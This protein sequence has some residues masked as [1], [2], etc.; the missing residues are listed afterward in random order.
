MDDGIR[1]AD[2]V[3]YYKKPIP[4]L[5]LY[6]NRIF[7]DVRKYIECVSKRFIEWFF[8]YSPYTYNNMADSISV[9]SFCWRCVQWLAI[10]DNY[11]LIVSQLLIFTHQFCLS[12]VRI[13]NYYYSYTLNIHIAQECGSISEGKVFSTLNENYSMLPLEISSQLKAIVIEF[14]HLMK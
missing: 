14:E 13:Q 11:T 4:F 5:L 6:L 9:V 1:F 10:H 7:F 2:A 8:L 12:V 3:I